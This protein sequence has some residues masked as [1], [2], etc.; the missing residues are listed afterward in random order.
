MNKQEIKGKLYRYIDLTHER[1]QIAEQIRRLEAIAYTPGAPAKS[2]LPRKAAVSDPTGD[3]AARLLNLREAY[4]AKLDQAV[5]AITEIEQLI[6]TLSDPVERR[7]I[8]CRYLEGKTWEQVCIEMN[9]SWRQVHRIHGRVLEKLARADDG[10]EWHS[11]PCYNGIV[12]IGNP[13][14]LS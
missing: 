9:Y 3:R 7:L 6:G 12:E 10:I 4:A 11:Q 8:R 5:Q 1:D 14:G 13:Q 2:G